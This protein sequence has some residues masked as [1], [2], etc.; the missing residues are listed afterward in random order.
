MNEQKAILGSAQHFWH[1]DVLAA[2]ILT[3]STFD[4]GDQ[5]NDMASPIWMVSTSRACLADVQIRK[6][7]ESG[8]VSTSVGQWAQ[9][10]E[11]Q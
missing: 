9:V 1:C 4:L 3:C 6:Q 11:G 2:F 10:S 5:P 8:L 7:T